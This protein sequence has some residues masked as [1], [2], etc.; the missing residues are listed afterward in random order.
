MKKIVLTGGPSSGKTTILKTLCEEF[1]DQITLV[2]EVAT[3]LLDGGFPIPGKDLPWSEAWQ[4]S[5][6]TAVLPVQSSLETAFAL[7]AQSSDCRLLICDRGLLDGAAYTPGGLKEFCERFHVDAAAAHKNYAAVIHLESLATADPT[8]Y[9]RA[10][11]EQRFEP[12][13]RAKML[14]EATRSAWD[15]HPHH[16]V[17]DGRRGI[18]GKISQVIGIVRFLLAEKG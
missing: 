4:E 3:L 12:L 11:N 5:L 18:E 16:L 7:K 15:G 13:E 8:K 17:I 2:P 10:G 1:G 14:E 9:G 6:Q